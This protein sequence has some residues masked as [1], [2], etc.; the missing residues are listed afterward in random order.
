MKSV[1]QA[2]TKTPSVV[3]S[4]IWKQG[5]TTCKTMIYGTKEEP[6]YKLVRGVPVSHFM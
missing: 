5:G 2:Q 3:G 1:K 4:V 6:I